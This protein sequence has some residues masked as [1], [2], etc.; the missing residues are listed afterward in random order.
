MAGLTKEEL[1]L[2]KDA[3]KFFDAD[4]SGEI[5]TQEVKDKLSEL[6]RKFD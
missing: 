6:G 5:T 3:F 2:L 4:N 1:D